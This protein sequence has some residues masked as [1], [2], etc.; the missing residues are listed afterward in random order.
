MSHPVR[1][2][3]RGLLRPLAAYEPPT[4]RGRRRVE[5]DGQLALPLRLRAATARR[6]LDQRRPS[7]Q[8]VPPAP[9]ARELAA[10]L[11]ALFEVAAGRRPLVRVRQ[12]LTE[13]LCT[14]IKSAPATGLG[15]GY[16]VNRVH[17]CAPQPRVIEV[18]AAAHHRRTDRAVAIA[19]RLEASW[20]GWRFTHFAIIAPP[21]G[22]RSDRLSAA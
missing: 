12:L 10:L 20:T 13:D 19:A 1:P 14:E 15:C 5:A 11:T 21:R 7:T 18:C 17:H 9:S 3:H 22:D 6:S 4:S 8:P 16:A 2:A